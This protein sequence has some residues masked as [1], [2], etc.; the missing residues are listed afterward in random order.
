MRSYRLLADGHHVDEAGNLIS[1]T[2][3]DLRDPVQRAPITTLYKASV[4]RHAVPGCETIRLSK[5]SCFLGQ[6]E[7]PRWSGEQV[8]GAPGVEPDGSAG[9]SGAGK[10]NA[11]GPSDDVHCGTNVWIYCASIEP[12]TPGERAAWRAAMPPGYDAVSPIRRPREFA[13]ALGA[14]TA[15]QIGPLGRPVLLRNTVDG[16]AFCTAHKH[17]RVYHGPVAYSEDPYRRLEKA[18]SALEF[19]LLLVFMKD[20]AHRAQREYR[21]AVWTGDDPAE[22]VLDLD[23]SAA[24]VDAMRKRRP[25]PEGSGFVR[26]GAAEYSAVE[27]PAGDGFS[28]ARIETLPAF[29]GTGRPTV[30]PRPYDDTLPGDLRETATV[31]AV[32][33]A[34]HEAVDRADA[35]CRKDA[36]AA[37]WH[38]ESVLGFLSAEFGCAITGVRVSEDGLIVVTAEFSAARAVEAS[39]A[40]GPE[41]TCACKFSAGDAHLASTAPD[42]RSFE[43]VLKERLA[44]VGV[45]GSGR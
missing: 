19:A 38:A 10:A 2:Y 3:V 7:G 42:V 33:E 9:D 6:G 21:F 26:A 27:E 43:R 14:M 30:A 28:P 44:E 13:R 4:K 29:L 23:V 12:E 8:P 32:V 5:P 24:L 45:L 37:A 15:E 16:Q 17:Q 34:L 22:D 11:T 18:A 40:V 20:A 35:G 1:C 31:R 39:I 36:A 25:Q 41:G